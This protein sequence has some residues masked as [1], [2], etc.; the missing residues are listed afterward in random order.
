MRPPDDLKGWQAWRGAARLSR[1][2][3]TEICC[4]AKILLASRE[5]HEEREYFRLLSENLRNTGAKKG[6]WAVRKEKNTSKGGFNAL[7]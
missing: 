6:H 7:I 2:G 1:A 3:E 4:E 5:N